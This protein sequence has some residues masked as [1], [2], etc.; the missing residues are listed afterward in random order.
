[1][2]RRDGTLRGWVVG[3]K[4]THAPSRPDGCGPPLL[5]PPPP[6]STWLPC[7]G[8]VQA[9]APLRLP[10]NPPNQRRT[11]LRPGPVHVRQPHQLHGPPPTVVPQSSVVCIL[12]AFCFRQPTGTEPAREGP[13]CA[14]PLPR[15][16]RPP[17][18]PTSFWPAAPP[19]R[20]PRHAAR[21][22]AASSS[23][24]HWAPLAR[25]QHP[26][27][28]T[29]QRVSTPPPPHKLPSARARSAAR[30]RVPSPRASRRPSRQRILLAIAFQKFTPPLARQAAAPSNLYASRQTPGARACARARPPSPPG[31]C[32]PRAF[33]FPRA[34]RNPAHPAC[35]PA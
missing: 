7:P 17:L 9:A 26:P 32:L 1:M 12:P 13:F 22:G 31:R 8:P 29:P 27:V 34:A 3:G 18:P 16:L 35:C 33:S 15:Q 5:A 24:F 11:G 14:P 21:R 19:V 28:S 10:G 25:A 30:P 6:P 2:P 4:R 20:P 23:L